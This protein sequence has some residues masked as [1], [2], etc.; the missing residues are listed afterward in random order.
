MTDIR[1]ATNSPQQ[2]GADEEIPF[3]VDTSDWPGTGDPTSVNVELKKYPDLSDASA[4]LQGTSSVNGNIIT[5]ERI[6]G[7][8]AGAM[9]RLEVKWTKGGAVQECYI[10]IEVTI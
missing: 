6:V 8:D 5:C 10:D 9:Y 7:A 2:I 1:R 4:L 3:W